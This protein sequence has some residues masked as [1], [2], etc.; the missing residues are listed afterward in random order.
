MI[1]FL[2]YPPCPPLWFSFWNL[3]LMHL[4]AFWLSGHSTAMGTE[5]EAIF[6]A[7]FQ[8]ESYPV[9]MAGD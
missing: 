2:S 3:Y 7:G 1:N 4:A 8:Y 5:K 6:T 9:S